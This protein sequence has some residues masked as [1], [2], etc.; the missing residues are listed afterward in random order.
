MLQCKRNKHHVCNIVIFFSEKKPQFFSEASYLNT[1]MQTWAQR[2]PAD[3]MKVP[4]WKQTLFSP[5]A[6][7]KTSFV[8]FCFFLSRRH[9]TGGRLKW[10]EKSLAEM[11]EVKSR[12]SRNTGGLLGNHLGKWTRRAE[13]WALKQLRRD[14]TGKENLHACT[15]S[16]LFTVSC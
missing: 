12:R 6:V 4:R 3:E 2:L 13:T 7:G 9:L 1:N 15:L 14:Q 10:C 5:S 16:P 8:F 11:Q